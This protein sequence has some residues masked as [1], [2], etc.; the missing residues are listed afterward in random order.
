[1]MI[2]DIL[3]KAGRMAPRVLYS[4]EMGT[5]CQDILKSSTGDRHGWLG[6]RGSM[7]VLAWLAIKELVE[8]ARDTD[9]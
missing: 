6:D 7:M 8:G 9:M 5:P 2:P 1:M 4:I 3:G